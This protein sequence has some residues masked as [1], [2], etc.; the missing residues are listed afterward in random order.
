MN[1]LKSRVETALGEVARTDIP[2]AIRRLADLDDSG[3]IYCAL[4]D[5][6]KKLAWVDSWIFDSGCASFRADQTLSPSVDKK[7][8][9]DIVIAIQAAGRTS[10]GRRPARRRCDL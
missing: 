8:D 5:L 6:R 9:P 1:D 7:A 2:D 3:E 10:S 4:T